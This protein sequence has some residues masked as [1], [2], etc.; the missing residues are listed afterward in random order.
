MEGEIG[1]CARFC[2]H[3]A[4]QM[5]AL[6]VGGELKVLVVYDVVAVKNRAGLMP[7]N[8]HCHT[9]RNAGADHVANGRSPKVVELP[10]PDFCSFAGRLQRG[11]VQRCL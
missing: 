2:A 9:F 3:L 8:G 6:G 4:F 10:C 5:L 1:D 11:T 7:G